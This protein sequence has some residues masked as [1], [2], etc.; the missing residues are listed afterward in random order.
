[1]PD[2]AALCAEWREMLVRRRALGDALSLWT[3]VLEGWRDWND[4]GEAPLGWP[5]KEGRRMWER[6]MPLL[7]DAAPALVPESL[8]DLLGPL[9]ERLAVGSRMAAEAL[10]RFAAA[11]D[12]GAVGP[13]VFFSAYRQG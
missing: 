1:M 7:A 2:Y 9:M 3:S 10:G 8:E 4:R 5:G 6:G 11:W 12:E 13:A